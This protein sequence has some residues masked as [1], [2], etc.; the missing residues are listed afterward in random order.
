MFSLY[1]HLREKAAEFPKPTNFRRLHRRAMEALTKGS[2]APLTS[3]ETKE[4]L[5][6]LEQESAATEEPEN[7]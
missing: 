2:R 5:N 4:M 3:A 7:R 1:D 6:E